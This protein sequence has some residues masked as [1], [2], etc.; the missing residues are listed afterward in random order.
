MPTITDEDPKAG[1]AGTLDPGATEGERDGVASPSCLLP[2]GP[3]T[4]GTRRLPGESR[5]LETALPAATTS[6]GAPP[7]ACPLPASDK[8]TQAHTP[9]V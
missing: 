9:L 6:G 7:C 2:N 5:C 4:P 1:Q 8:S 3:S